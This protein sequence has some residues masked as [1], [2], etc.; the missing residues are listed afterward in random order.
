MLLITR[1]I[2]IK[3]LRDLKIVDNI[4]GIHNEPECALVQF[5]FES[6]LFPPSPASVQAT[7]QADSYADS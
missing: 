7:F 6:W 2:T 1:S 3:A 4:T 5:I